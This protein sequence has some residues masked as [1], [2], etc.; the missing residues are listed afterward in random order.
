M[1]LSSVLVIASHSQSEAISYLSSRTTRSLW[2]RLPHC[3][4][5]PRRSFHL[6]ANAFRTTTADRRND[7][8]SCRRWRL[9]P[10]KLVRSDKLGQ[11]RESSAVEIAAALRARNDNRSACRVDLSGG[12]RRRTTPWYE[13]H[14]KGA[15][16]FARLLESGSC[17]QDYINLHYEC[18]ILFG[19]PAFSSD[20]TVPAC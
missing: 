8:R 10:S 20:R 13:G 4:R 9:L 15:G 12:C 14:K 3:A 17:T 5:H 11:H 16:Q 1:L 19:Y 18:F 2:L 6:L 7:N